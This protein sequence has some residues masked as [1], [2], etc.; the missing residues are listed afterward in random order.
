MK[1][2]DEDVERYCC[3]QEHVLGLQP[4][5]HNQDVRYRIRRAQL[6]VGLRNNFFGFFHTKLHLAFISCWPQPL[7]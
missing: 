7:R 5:H 1:M 2:E 4:L 3:G 6:S